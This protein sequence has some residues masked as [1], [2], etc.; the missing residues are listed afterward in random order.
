[1]W[2]LRSPLPCG[3]WCFPSSALV[4]GAAFPDVSS[5]VVMRS[6][7]LPTLP[8]LPVR[9]CISV[10]CL[11][12][13]QMYACFHGHKHFNKQVTR[14]AE[15]PRECPKEA[16]TGQHDCGSEATGGRV[17]NREREMS[18]FQV[19]SKR[20]HKYTNKDRRSRNRCLNCNKVVSEPR[21]P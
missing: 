13:L 4:D 19:K 1:M 6:L 16:K 2:C 18:E 8:S 7:S 12:L 14:T 17:T 5:W 3:W 9:F 21:R 15:R 20:D 10:Q 11:F